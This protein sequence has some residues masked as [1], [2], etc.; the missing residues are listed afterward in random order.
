M[1]TIKRILVPVDFS[2]A[3]DRALDVAIDVAQKFDAE[4]IIAHVYT[5]PTALYGG[6]LFWPSD[7]YRQDVSEALDKVVAGAQAR[8]PKVGKV[9]AQGDPRHKILEIA[10]G[11]GADLIVMGTQGRRGLEHALLGSV[12]EQIL[13]SARVPVLTVSEGGMARGERRAGPQAAS[14]SSR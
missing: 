3:A 10:D 12:T 11:P 8:Y 14:A 2:S 1:F 9:L 6:T 13:R 4:L 5:L 7:D